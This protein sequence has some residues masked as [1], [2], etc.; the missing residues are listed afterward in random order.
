MYVQRPVDQWASFEHVPAFQRTRLQCRMSLRT[1]LSACPRLGRG[2]GLATSP[3]THAWLSFN[4]EKEKT[5][6]HSKLLSKDQFVYEMVTDFVIPSQW[7]QYLANKKL[8]IEFTKD[9]PDIK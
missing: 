3:S 7:D 1:V 4:K 8:Q 9:S 5:S 6:A 2:R